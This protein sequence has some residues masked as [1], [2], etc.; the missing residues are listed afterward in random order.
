MVDRGW[1]WP[2]LLSLFIWCCFWPDKGLELL[3]MINLCPS[4]LGKDAFTNA[5]PT[6][7]PQGEGRELSLYLFLLNCLRFNVPKYQIW[8]WYILPPLTALEPRSSMTLKNWTLL[9]EGHDRLRPSFPHLKN[10]DNKISPL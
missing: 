1:F 5:Y 10:G 4:W 7:R 9:T 6:F 2:G 8:T 3:L